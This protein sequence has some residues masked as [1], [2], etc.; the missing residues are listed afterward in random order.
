[1]HGLREGVSNYELGDC[2]HARS[3][4]K[5]HSLQLLRQVLQGELSTEQT[6]LQ[7][8]QNGFGDIR[9]AGTCSNGTG[10]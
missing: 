5:E 7:V 9:G 6:H 1:M 2:P 3:Q 4:F 10:R 8:P